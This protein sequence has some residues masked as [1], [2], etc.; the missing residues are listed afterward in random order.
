M[1][2]LR[3]AI[4]GAVGFSFVPLRLST[5]FGFL[6]AVPSFLAVL[7]SMSQRFLGFSVFGHD[8][9][10]VPGIA[11]LAMGLF[12]LGGVTLLMLGILGEYVARIYLEVKRRP[13]YVVAHDTARRERDS[14]TIS[15]ETR[16]IPSSRGS[17]S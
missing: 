4:S 13:S 12:S 10:Q 14:D 6:V 9:T 15:T 7:F 2:L 5:L 17:P 16:A 8:A 3:L 11:I 1:G